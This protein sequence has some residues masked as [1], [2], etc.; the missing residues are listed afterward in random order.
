MPRSVPADCGRTSCLACLA[1]GGVEFH[2][3]GSGGLFPARSAE[4]AVLSQLYGA[5]TFPFAI[6]A[7]AGRLLELFVIKTGNMLQV[8]H[9][10]AVCQMV[11]ASALTVYVLLRYLMAIARRTAEGKPAGG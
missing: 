9:W 4:T 5:F 3:L 2:Q 11:L 6:S 10:I 1:A 8:W 7:M